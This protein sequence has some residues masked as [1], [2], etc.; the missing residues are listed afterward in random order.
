MASLISIADGNFTDASTWALVNSTSYLDSE[1]GSTASTTSLV[2]SSTFTP[3]AITVDG[4][5]VKIARRTASPSGTVTVGLYLNAGSVLVDS[6][7]INAT[8]IANTLSGSSY[9]RGWVFFKFSSS[10]TLLAAT[11]YKV[12]FVTSSSGTVT[13]YRN[14]T[15]GNWSRMLRTTTTQAPASGDQL[16]IIGEWTAAATSTSFTVT[17]NN[18]ASTSFGPTVSGG[19]PQGITIGNKGTL[20]CETS[21]STA[22][23]LKFKGVFGVYDGGT[24]NLGTSGTPIPST[25]SLD[26][27]MDSVANVDT[28]FSWVQGSTINIYGYPKFTTTFKSYLNTDEAIASTVLGIADTTGWENNDEICIATTTATAS[29]C[30]K[31]T[32][33]TVDSSTQVTISAGLTY[34]H[35]GTSPTQAEVGNLTR[36]VKIHGIGTNAPSTSTTL[37]GYIVIDATAIVTIRYCEFYYLGSN[38]TN[39]RCIEIATTTGT[40]SM[41]YC[42]VYNGWITGSSVRVT[43]SSGSGISISHN[44]FYNL[45]GDIFTISSSSTGTWLVDDNIFMLSGSSSNICVLLNDVGGTF[46][47]NIIV[48][49]NAS[50]T[51]GVR[52]IESGAVIGTFSGNVS[53]GN[54]GY[55]IE[56]YTAGDVSSLT[57][58]RNG[59]GILISASNL[60]LDGLTAFGNNIFHL[61]LAGLGIILRNMTLDSGTTFTTNM[62][63]R[64]PTGSTASA[65]IEDSTF[66]SGTSHSSSDIGFLPNGST[67]F[68]GVEVICRNCLF[69]SSTELATQSAM[70]SRSFFSSQKH[71]QTNGNHK[72]WLPMGTITSDTTI[73]R[74]SSPSTRFTPT[75]TSTKLIV[76]GQFGFT[77]KVDNGNT[78]TASIYVRKSSVSSGDAANYNGNH[79]RLIVRK[80]SSA[81]ISNDTVLATA[82]V[83]SE[84]AWELLTGTTASVT[85]DAVLEF[86]VDCDGTTGWI[87]IDDFS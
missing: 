86:V 37:Q 19:P 49:N 6:A 45:N 27:I 17:M 81:G 53:H 50:N 48:G 52:L 63:I 84:G 61:Y 74:T 4:I 9:N 57:V 44:I 23:V 34:A 67:T 83:A 85:D 36:N 71:D 73:Y 65:I 80:N 60:L 35:S 87:N 54:L 20:T 16:H 21:A 13:L 79:P 7:T 51:S 31:R 64:F 30:E 70:L 75:K 59:S 1:A 78:S 10:Q 66:G 18:T 40:F 14:A 69:A 28:G 25:S 56:F 22:Y 3:G 41:E 76:P 38:T 58:W 24:L 26:I 12:G 43:S 77:K 42:S 62:G 8:D 11:A 2:Y 55:G 5:A 29:Q 33:S 82:T 68:T 15:A 32:I 39:K 46:T 47:N 72:V